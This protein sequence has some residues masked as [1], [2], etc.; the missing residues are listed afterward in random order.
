MRAEIVFDC[1]SACL[2]GSR[3]RYRCAAFNPDPV[4]AQLGAVKLGLEDDVPILDTF[5]EHIVAEGTSLA[6]ALADL[7][8]FSEG[9]RF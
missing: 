4:I 1:Q 3:R 7:D 2:E 8:A 6:G 9:Y 5:N